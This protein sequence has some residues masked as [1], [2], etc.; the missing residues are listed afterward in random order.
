M[1]S[2]KK[3][4]ITGCGTIRITDMLRSGIPEAKE[5]LKEKNTMSRKGMSITNY[6]AFG[7]NLS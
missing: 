6:A 1:L 3:L 4:R 7:R 5:V 2:S